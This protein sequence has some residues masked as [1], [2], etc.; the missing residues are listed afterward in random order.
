MTISPRTVLITGASSGLGAEFADR[1]ARRG[2]DLVLVA[3]REDR[4]REIAERLTRDRGVRVDVIPLDL[5]QPNASALLRERLDDAGIRIDG[6]INNAGFGM[7]GPLAEADPARLDAMVQLNVA[8]LTSLTREFL[9]DILAADG[10]LVNIASAVAYQPFPT[11]AAYGASKAYVLSF[12]EAIA[13]EARGT[14]ARILAVS[15]GTTRT[16]FFDVVGDEIAG[17]GGF[18]T[19][20]QVVDRAL[21]ALDARSRPASVVTGWR[22]AVLATLPGILPRRA[23][24]AITG[25]MM[26]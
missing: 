11:M 1:F 3:R 14:N 13:Y 19:A 12:T 23:T 16:E 18:Q 10:M 15:P 24:L 9:P 17:P 25:R 6:L 22:N 26:G 7:H 8:S 20:E 21:R 4:L 5:G 2:S